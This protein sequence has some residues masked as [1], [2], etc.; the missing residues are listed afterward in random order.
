MLKAVDVSKSYMSNTVLSD[1]SFEV[2]EKEFVSIVGASGEGK[3]T[4]ARILCGTVIPDSGRIEFNGEPLFTVKEY[5]KKL[6]REV[7]LIPQ[8]AYANLD[9]HQRIGDAIS[10]PLLFHKLVHSKAG[11]ERRAKEL[12]EQVQLAPE[13]YVRRPGELSG[14]QAQRV[15][16]ARALTVSPSLLIADEATSMLDMTSQAQVVR[17]F[18]HLIADHG[19][20]ILLISH[21]QAL[22]ESVSDRI[23]HLSGGEM[24]EIHYN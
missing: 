15:L 20:S 13:L 1:V 14:G 21:N 8:Q 16:I 22:V 24:L 4:I 5:N 12:M 11:A 19:I 23:Y 3:S 17:I 9:P 10:E 7:Q 2:G 18:K 6:R